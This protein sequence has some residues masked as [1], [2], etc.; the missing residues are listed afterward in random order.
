MELLDLMKMRRSIRKYKNKQII[1]DDLKKIIEA[2]LYAPNAGGGQRGIIYACQNK[3]LNEKIGKNNIN[4]FNK[5]NLI[6]SYVSSEQPSIIDDSNI[7][8]GFYCAPTVIVIFGPINF[9]YS[10]PDSF[11]IAENIVLEAKELGIDS[12]II[13][14][15]EETFD[16]EFGKEVLEKWEVPKNYIARV[17]VTL[18]Y[19]E[20][21]YPNIK[22][23]KENRFRIIK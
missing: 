10:I 6:G 2:G 23:I 21:E 11:C 7:K 16:N 19:V 9:L 15:A 4:S 22:Q 1:E 5:N 20:G 12:C 3:E 17:F 18:G 13:A 8:S 14:R